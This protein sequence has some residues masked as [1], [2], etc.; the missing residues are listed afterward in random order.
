MGDLPVSGEL[1]P[2]ARAKCKR[3][4]EKKKTKLVLVEY[5]KGNRLFHRLALLLVDAMFK[6][7]SN[8]KIQM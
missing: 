1:T 4:R 6:K 5:F 2:S 3:K 7:W 8:Y